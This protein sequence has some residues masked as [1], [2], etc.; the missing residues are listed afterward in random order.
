MVKQN[1]AGR[2][3]IPRMLVSRALLVWLILGSGTSAV[4]GYTPEDPLVQEMLERGIQFLEK[5]QET[6]QHA[7]MLGGKCLVALACYKHRKNAQHPR[8]VE[9]VAACRELAQRSERSFAHDFNYSL[10]I[11]VIFLCEL[12]ASQY[13][14]EIQFFL[15]ALLERQRSDG[16]WSYPNYETG[17]TS[18]TQYGALGAWVAS[19]QGFPVP[20]SSVE[21]FCNWLI[22]TQDPSGAFAYQGRDPGAGNARIQQSTAEDGIRLTMSPAA[23]GSLYIAADLLGISLQNNRQDDEE[24]IFAKIPTAPASPQT[25]VDI[26]RLRRALADG[27]SYFQRN[28]RLD[29]PR[30]E[31]YNLYSIERYETFREL[32]EGKEEQEPDWYNAGV[33]FLTRKQAE[34]GAWEGIRGKPVSTAFATLF[35]MRSTRQ[36]VRMVSDGA[37]VGGRY[38]PADLT[39][40]RLEGGQVVGKE[41][42]GDLGS[43]IEQLESGETVDT[44]SMLADL[45]QFRFGRDEPKQDEQLARLKR[46]V[47]GSNYQARLLA[48]KAL[49]N[50]ADLEYAP[51]LI[52]ALGDGDPRVVREAHNGLRLLSRRLSVRPLGDQ[53]TPA[54]KRAAQQA[55][56][57]WLE[58]IRPDIEIPSDAF[59]PVSER[60]G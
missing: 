13:A 46:M 34:S 4:W 15:G 19:K 23:L 57:R 60:D 5:G 55:W 20:S 45:E 11:A 18:Q 36:T 52:Y 31:Y 17:D 42:R 9:A 12:D 59:L 10:G 54:Q 22:R 26:G 48:V 50:S 39:K 8:V 40:V 29:L 24:E 2:C 16:A 51:V 35:L 6:D 33:D 25:K 27:V 1:V 47:S 53:P 49:A 30:N 56:A 41:L 28:F 44:D 43:L 7:G 21:A 38:L 14:S 32:A 3:G 58:G 37:L